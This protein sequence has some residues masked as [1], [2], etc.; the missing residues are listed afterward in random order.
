MPLFNGNKN[1]K[2]TLCLVRH[3]TRSNTVIPGN[4]NQANTY[5]AITT[6]QVAQTFSLAQIPM[7]HAPVSTQHQQIYP[8]L[9]ASDSTSPST[10]P[11]EPSAPQQ[12]QFA[13]PTTSTVRRSLNPE[14]A[15]AAPPRVVLNYDSA[16]ADLL[17]VVDAGLQCIIPSQAYGQER[18]QTAPD[19]DADL[20]RNM[21]RLQVP[22][23]ATAAATAD[24]ELKTTVSTTTRNADHHPKT[25]VTTQTIQ[26]DSGRQSNVGIEIVNGRTLVLYNSDIDFHDAASRLERVLSRNRTKDLDQHMYQDD[27]DNF[28]HHACNIDLEPYPCVASAVQHMRNIYYDRLQVQEQDRDDVDV[29]S[30]DIADNTDPDIVFDYNARECR[31]NR[32]PFQNEEEVDLDDT[33]PYDD[34]DSVDE[35]V[36]IESD[37]YSGES[38]ADTLVTAQDYLDDDEGPYFD[39]RDTEAM[40]R[41]RHDLEVPPPYEEVAQSSQGRRFT[42]QIPYRTNSLVGQMER[43][44]PRRFNR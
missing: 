37:Q 39:E 31:S 38:D 11:L 21:L 27:I 28:V 4:P 40:N 8:N 22:D 26:Q 12:P 36:D 1:T 16:D 23:G 32:I 33:L 6:Q 13:L 5:A 19:D 9:S 20:H 34:P 29:V 41:F 3:N 44:F 25:P 42:N 35:G 43:L 24:T 30:Q 15:A 18:F 14:M 17:D 2:A 10:S 7:Q